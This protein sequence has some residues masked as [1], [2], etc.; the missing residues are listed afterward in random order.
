[1]QEIAPRRQ[2]VN[3]P[4]DDEARFVLTT[5]LGPV[6]MVKLLKAQ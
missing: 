1:M 3:A 2:Y 5:L 4:T 6:L